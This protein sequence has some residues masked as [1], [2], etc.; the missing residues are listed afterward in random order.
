VFV[1]DKLSGLYFTKSHAIRI[2]SPVTFEVVP[3]MVHNHRV[4]STSAHVSDIH[5]L[6][7]FGDEAS[8]NLTSLIELSVVTAKSSPVL[9]TVLL[10]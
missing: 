5:Y 10:T 7:V 1:L 4:E 6:W 3:L 8:Q 9:A 2:H